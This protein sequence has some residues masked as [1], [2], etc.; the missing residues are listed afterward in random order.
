MA[1]EKSIRIGF[2]LDGV[3]I[4]K[5]PLVPRKVLEWFVREHD[6][7]NPRFRYPK[8][9]LERRLRWF[10]HYHRFRP[11]IVKNLEFVKKISKDKNYELFV[12][13]GRYSFLK[14]RTEQWFK[15][16]KLDGVFKEIHLNLRNEQ[17]HVFKEKLLKKLKPDYFFE[18]DELIV[19]YLKKKLEN[20]GI[21]IHKVYENSFR[22]NIL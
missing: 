22:F 4:G 11:P 3:I 14:E 18:D 12:I 8:F 16:H 1:K 5:P 10:T 2:D 6:S 7:K 21:I 9:F 19:N 17:P 13:S 15:V 20:R